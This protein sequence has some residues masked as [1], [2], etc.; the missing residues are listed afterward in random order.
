MYF[1]KGCHSLVKVA[2]IQNIS[3]FSL[4]I[5]RKENLSTYAYCTKDNS[6][7]HTIKKRTLKFSNLYRVKQINNKWI[8]NCTS[9]LV[10]FR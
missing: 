4:Y 2:K 8:G 1:Q 10:C 3:Y 9:S 5:D 6:G 7:T